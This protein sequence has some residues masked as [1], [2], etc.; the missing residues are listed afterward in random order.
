MFLNN[1][2]TRW[3]LQ[4]V[5]NALRRER[6]PIYCERHHIIPRCL[7]GT[8]VSDNIALLTARE[9]FVAHLLLTKMT[10]KDGWRLVYALKRMTHDAWGHR[11]FT[12]TMYELARR[13]FVATV[14][15]R[16]RGRAK[17]ASTRRKISE[18]LRGRPTG[19]AGVPFSDDHKNALS[20]AKRGSLG[21]NS[22][23][24][25]VTC[26]DSSVLFTDNRKQFCADRGLNFTSVKTVS[27][28]G[29]P[30]KGYRFEKVVRVMPPGTTPDDRDA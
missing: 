14:S 6:P 25:R 17:P 2:Y 1:K 9:H 5:A 7:G 21:N 12:S 3:Y 28:T 27:Q 22:H 24:W 20:A 29:K 11:Q 15:D 30:Y 10:E 16:N 26:P 4:L 18:S 13:K 23:R 19:R 8:D